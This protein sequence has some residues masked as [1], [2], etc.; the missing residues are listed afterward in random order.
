MS[1][2]SVEGHLKRVAIHDHWHFHVYDSVTGEAIRCEFPHEML[3]DVRHALSKR[4]IV[5]GDITSTPV[6]RITQLTAD[7]IRVLPGED[8]LPSLDDLRGSVPRA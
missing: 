3:E 8:E 6:G 5:L 2:G 4:V 7:E 1:V